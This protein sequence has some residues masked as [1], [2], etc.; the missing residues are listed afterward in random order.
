VV[1][2]L[3]DT[4]GKPGLDVGGAFHFFAQGKEVVK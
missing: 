4:V 1:G 3:R 2:N